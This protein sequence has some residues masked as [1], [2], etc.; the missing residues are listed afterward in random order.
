MFPT[1]RAHTC[2]LGTTLLAR[3]LRYEDDDERPLMFY[4]AASSPEMFAAVKKLV[5]NT[6]G[7]AGLVEQLRHQ[8]A[9]GENVMMR[10][11]NHSGV[12]TA[13]WALLE[14]TG[15]LEELLE[16]Q[17]K[18]GKS[19]V[20]HAAEV[21]NLAVFQK[22]D[23]GLAHVYSLFSATDRRGWSGFMYAARARGEHSTDFLSMLCG[24]CFA[25]IKDQP[26]L[27]REL[28]R[29]ADDDNSTMLMHSARG[30]HGSYALV[31]RMLRDSGCIGEDDEHTTATLLIWAARGGDINVLNAV[32]GGIKVRTPLLQ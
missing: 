24:L 10:A 31:C 3:Q 4:A 6:I 30:G 22:L 5:K 8:C 12:F 27:V 11:S 7:N 2:Q 32:A 19:W 18:Q 15:C 21:S 20:L 16:E 29:T 14:R 17:D 28:T 9:K 1:N 25:E 13:V 23:R 26:R